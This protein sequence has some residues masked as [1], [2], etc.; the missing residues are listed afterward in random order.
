MFTKGNNC[1]DY[2]FALLDKKAILNEI[3]FENIMENLEKLG[4]FELEWLP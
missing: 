2:L 4:K 1:I 3:F